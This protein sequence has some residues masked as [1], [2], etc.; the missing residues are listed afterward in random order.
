MLDQAFSFGDMIIRFFTSLSGYQLACL[1]VCVVAVI[2]AF[3]LVS[4][5]LKTIL[6]ILAIVALLYFLFPDLFAGI[7]G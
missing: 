7:L 3:N 1:A 6:R 2:L 4:K 5:S